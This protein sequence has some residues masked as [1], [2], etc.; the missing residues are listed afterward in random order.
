MGTYMSQMKG[1]QFATLSSDNTLFLLA[2]C[3]MLLL[4]I[5]IYVRDNKDQQLTSQHW[6][7]LCF[8]RS[9]MGRAIFRTGLL[10]WSLLASWYPRA[11]RC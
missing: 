9:P 4:K 3:N 2:F 8:R 7:K 11:P 1:N 5:L 10:M 6:I